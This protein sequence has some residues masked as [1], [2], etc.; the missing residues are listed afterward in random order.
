MYYVACRIFTLHAVPTLVPQQPSP[1]AA[2][3]RFGN[4]PEDSVHRATKDNVH[5]ATKNNVHCATK[6]NVDR[7]T[8]A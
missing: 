5:R 1:I 7:A 6:D 8:N 3:F 2:P 4:L